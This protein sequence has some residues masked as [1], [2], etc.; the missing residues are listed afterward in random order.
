MQW[1]ALDN[2]EEMQQ[3]SLQGEHK[4]QIP[5]HTLEQYHVHEEEYFTKI[6]DS[7]EPKQKKQH[8]NNVE[9]QRPDPDPQQA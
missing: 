7:A 1:Y 5:Q 4:L 2:D 6:Q 3:N 8:P 9:A